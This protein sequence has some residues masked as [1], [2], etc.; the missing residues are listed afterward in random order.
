M[1]LRLEPAPA[2]AW[3]TDR[4]YDLHY[5]AAPQKIARKLMAE[6]EAEVDDGSRP[7]AH[8]EAQLGQYLAFPGERL[9]HDLAA[10]GCCSRGLSRHS[11]LVD[12]FH[13]F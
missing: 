9:C 5:Y 10:P 11:V 2:H 6:A 7:S 13:V 8:V 3:A 1:T 12:S 4:S